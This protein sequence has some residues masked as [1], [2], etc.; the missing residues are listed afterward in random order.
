MFEAAV[1]NIALGGRIVAIGMAGSYTAGANGEWKQSRHEARSFPSR[2]M[3]LFLRV[4]EM[5][6]PY[7]PLTRDRQLSQLSA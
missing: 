4:A 2:C 3:P 6:A 7:Q 5:C 1:D